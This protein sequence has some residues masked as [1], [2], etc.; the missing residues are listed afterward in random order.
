MKKIAIIA[1]ATLLTGMVGCA[2]SQIES[3]RG[4]D[5]SAVDMA[6]NIKQYT[7]KT[8][9]VGEQMLIPRTFTGQPPLVPHT[10]AKYEPITI[11]ENACLDC[12]ISDDFKGKKMPKMGESHFLKVNGK[13]KVNM[14]RYECTT[15]HVQQVDAPP[16]VENNFVGY[17][18]Q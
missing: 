17:I 12:H 5:V 16:L 3:M 7:D 9:G 2:T 14:A 8:P 11:E 10:I 1:L 18:K 15:C 13:E 6:P 4:K